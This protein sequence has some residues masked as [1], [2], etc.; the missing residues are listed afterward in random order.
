[1]RGYNERLFSGGFRSYLHRARFNWLAN[2]SRWVDTSSVFELGCFDA[3]SINYLPRRPARYVGADAN[4]EGGLDQ[5]RKLW[6]QYEFHF[7]ASPHDLT[8]ITGNFKCTLSMETME[9]IPADD[10]EAYIE[11]LARLTAGHLVITVPVEKGPVFLAKH[12]AKKYSAALSEQDGEVQSFS[13]S[14]V[15]CATIGMSQKVARGE[16]K[17]FDYEWLAKIVRKRFRI[18]E[19]TGHPY[20][21]MPRWLNFGVGIVAEPK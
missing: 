3:K 14:D 15:L 13:A 7:C 12:L 16:H 10:M 5:A 17:G 1:M 9:H 18:V 21:H 6:P 8:A 19:Y 11:Q 20:P 2:V 4:Y